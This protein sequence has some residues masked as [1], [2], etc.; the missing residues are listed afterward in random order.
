[1]A[2]D[3]KDFDGGQG[4]YREVSAGA[5]AGGM[6][7][8]PAASVPSPAPGAA[9]LPKGASFARLDK[10]PLVPN[11]STSCA[12]RD[13]PGSLVSM[14]YQINLIYEI[15]V[16]AAALVVLAAGVMMV[17]RKTNSRPLP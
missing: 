7:S 14:S 13:P 9:G 10:P 16:T 17:R 15:G 11:P 8:A 2:A 6:A 1:V 5:A 12:R 4:V 3:D